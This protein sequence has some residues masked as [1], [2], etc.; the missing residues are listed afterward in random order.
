M[1]RIDRSLIA[2]MKLFEGLSED[3]LD[4][5]LQGARI[6][7]YRKDTEIFHQGEEAETFFHL[8]KGLIRVVHTTQEGHQIVARYIS[9]GEMF[10]IAVALGFKAYPASA[11][12]AVDC[13][14]LVWPNSYWAKLSARFPSVMG[15]VYQTVGSRLQ[16]TQARVIAMST[17]QIEQRVAQA[18]LR[19]LDQ[20]DARGHGDCLSHY[21]P[22]H[23]RTD[24]NDA[25]FGEPVDQ[26]MGGGRY[27]ARRPQADYRR[28]PKQ[29]SRNRREIPQGIA[30]LSQ[31]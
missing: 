30:F 29:P 10:G 20:S 21:T 3:E 31:M 5:M 2:G 9:G 17:E 23:R 24:G 6:S 13:V 25:V 12:A 22:G 28:P 26:R 16:E 4:E 11:V 8:V 7:S 19:L 27:R 18:L 1:P 14:A 15:K